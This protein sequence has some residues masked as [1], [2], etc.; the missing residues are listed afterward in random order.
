MAPIA[1]VNCI[2]RHRTRGIEVAHEGLG[3]NCDEGFEAGL[4]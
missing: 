3:T 2:E 4:P 1:N